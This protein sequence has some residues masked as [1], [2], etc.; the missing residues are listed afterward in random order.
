MKDNYF[1]SMYWIPSINGYF[2]RSVVIKIQLP[3][4]LQSGTIEI[5]TISAKALRFNVAGNKLLK[6]YIIFALN[7]LVNIATYS[8][9]SE[10]ST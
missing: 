7:L 5:E 1:L 6:K 8:V 9:T 4:V 10:M 3:V 2:F